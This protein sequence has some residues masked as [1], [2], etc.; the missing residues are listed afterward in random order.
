MTLSP[1]NWNYPTR[2]WFGNGRI[3]DLPRACKQL[4]M[5]NPLLVTDEGLVALPI[6]E[7]TL[8]LLREAGI[9][10]GVYSEV[11]GN[12]T[13][14]NVEQGVAAYR[15]GNH[16]GVIALGG[17]SALDAGK[18]IALQAGQQRSLWDFEDIDDNWQHAKAGSIAPII[19]VPTT[20]GTGSEVGRAAVILDEENQRKKIIFH[21]ALLPAIVISDP[22]L[23]L[24]LPANIT[25]WTGIDA[26]VHA[27]EAYC[28]PGFHP[29]ADGIAVEA[30]RLIARWL[31]VAV[32]DGSNID[33]RGHMLVAASMGATAFQKGLG[34]IHSVS[35]VLGALFNTH[36]GLANAIILPYGLRQNRAAIDERMSYLCTVL[37]LPG[38]NTETVIEYLLGLRQQLQIPHSLQEIGI[39]VDRAE[40]I[41][42]LA[43]A[44]PCTG[45]N[46]RPVTATDLEMLF[47]AAHS[48]DLGSLD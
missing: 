3:A 47:R 26:L 45:T 28:A 12:P 16:G 29:M 17:G 44:D 6:V 33:A 8:A 9:E 40:E 13:G 2:I 21:P 42:R 7:D 11:Q 30:I 23:T 18:A 35:H 5:Q 25:A 31:P 1:G 15:D 34:C 20:A 10:H 39:D 46:A 43:L 24:G 36:H 48:G 14:R 38:N 19:A 22:Q 27:I 37:D 32:E 41:G 4:R